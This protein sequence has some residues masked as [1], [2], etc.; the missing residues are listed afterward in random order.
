MKFP[1]DSVRENLRQSGS[2]EKKWN[3]GLAGILALPS[4]S[5]WCLPRH[6]NELT[7]HWQ[8]SGQ[9]NVG[10]V[11]SGHIY[12]SAFQQ[13]EILNFCQRKL[14]QTSHR[15]T[16]TSWVPDVEY[17]T[18][19][20]T[21]PM[22]RIVVILIMGKSFWAGKKHYLWADTELQYRRCVKSQQ[23]CAEQLQYCI[24]HLEILGKGD[25]TARQ[26]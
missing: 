4:P 15:N 26:I 2:Y 12:S 10:H 18:F 23:T 25:L 19:K 14:K 16:L 7:A 5:R 6:G 13:N 21:E 1:A 9:R 8:M 20:L 3:W 11:C 17:K 22:S 24:L